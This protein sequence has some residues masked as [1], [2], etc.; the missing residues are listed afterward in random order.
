MWAC[1]V[2]I[3][4]RSDY[5]MDDILTIH[6]RDGETVRGAFVKRTKQYLHIRQYSI[7]A[8]GELR[9]MR[10]DRLLIPHEIVAL[11]EVVRP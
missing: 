6:R 8:G 4:S 5:R 11:V 10:G 7:E 3:R 9:A 1:G 2:V